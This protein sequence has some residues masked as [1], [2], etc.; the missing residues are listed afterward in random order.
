VGCCHH[1]WRL[2][3]A[4]DGDDIG[5]GATGPCS[6]MES[7]SPRMPFAFTGTLKRFLVVLEPDKVTPGEREGL[8]EQEARGSMAAQ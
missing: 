8:L 5:K 4:Y 7:W 1:V 3:F 6:W 2:R